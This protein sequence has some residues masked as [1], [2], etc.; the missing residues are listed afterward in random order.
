M[1]LLF[2]VDE[3]S[4]LSPS[5]DK[6][7]EVYASIQEY[8]KIEYDGELNKYFGIDLDHHPYGSIHISQPYITQRILNM[9]T[10]MEKSS[11]KPTPAVKPPLAKNE[12]SQARQI[13]LVTYQ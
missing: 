13:N 6:I 10:G 8:F 11:A 5:K 9:I 4:M 3:C 12:G 2:Y 1:V 7:Y